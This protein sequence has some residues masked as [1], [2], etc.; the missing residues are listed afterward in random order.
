MRLRFRYSLRGLGVLTAIIAAGLAWYVGRIRPQEQAV[1]AIEEAGGMVSYAG[2][3]PVND[4]PA[5]IDA[6]RRSFGEVRLV[7]VKGNGSA[8]G[9]AI[10]AH[11]ACLKALRYVDLESMQIS[12]AD[13]A[14][15][16]K[17]TDLEVLY[18][19]GNPITDEGLRHLAALPRL[20]WLDLG[21]TK[22]TESGVAT[23]RRSLPNCTIYWAKH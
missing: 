19:N 15:L 23:L 6:W 13:L 12:D 22:V 17:L 5:G 16:A 14:Q 1:T 8:R 20:R 10:C 21:G 7:W 18:L 9:D 11:L 3:T 2:S 4:P